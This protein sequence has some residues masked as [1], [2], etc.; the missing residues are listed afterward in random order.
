MD[1]EQL[2]QGLSDHEKLLLLF[3]YLGPL[4]LV[5]LKPGASATQQEI[6]DHVRQHL[7]GFKV[8]SGVE[9]RDELPKGST[10]KILKRVLREPYWDNAG[11]SI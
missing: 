11:R 1:S 7:A 2:D 5:S 6:R 8:P 10:G 3:G 9:F 4:A